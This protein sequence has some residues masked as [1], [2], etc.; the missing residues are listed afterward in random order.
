M[1]YVIDRFEE[2]YVILENIETKEKK[3][4][5]KICL[6]PYIEEG[7]ILIRTEEGYILDEETTNQRRQEILEKFNRLKNTF[8][9]N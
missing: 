5:L 7:S 8:Y 9:D 6:P 2:N 1:K 3:E 4:I